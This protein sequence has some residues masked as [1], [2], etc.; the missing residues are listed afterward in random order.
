M[1]CSRKV[2]QPYDYFCWITLYFQLF[3]A[4]IY[5]EKRLNGITTRKWNY[6]TN[7]YNVD[8]EVRPHREREDLHGA[9]RQRAQDE[10]GRRRV[11]R[12]GARGG[13]DVGGGGGRVVPV[14]RGRPGWR[15]NGI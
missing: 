13:A 9:E 2:T 4:I 12:A 1:L 8:L 14:R 15:F 6:K 3:L 5:L 10:V 7:S 11:P